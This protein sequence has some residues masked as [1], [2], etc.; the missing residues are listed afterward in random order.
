MFACGGKKEFLRH[1][2]WVRQE[3]LLNITKAQKAN[4][5][6]PAACYGCNHQRT[7]VH[8]SLHPAVPPPGGSLAPILLAVHKGINIYIFFPIA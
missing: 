4:I 2:S 1:I 8:S 6:V 3:L 7:C 5:P